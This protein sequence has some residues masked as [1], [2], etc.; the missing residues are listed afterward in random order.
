MGT[1]VVIGDPGRV[2]GYALAGATIWP[3]TDAETVRRAWSALD[4]RTALVILTEA[5]AGSLT[6]EQRDGGPLTVVM[7]E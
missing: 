6:A 3:A 7:P 1:V 5:A 2:Q 4:A